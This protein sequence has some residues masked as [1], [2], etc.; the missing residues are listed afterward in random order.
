MG[1]TTND[2]DSIDWVKL[3]IFFL[4]LSAFLRNTTQD[5]RI[6]E[7]RDRVAICEKT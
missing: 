1:I 2:L 4:A 5:F 7:L 6:N 3:L